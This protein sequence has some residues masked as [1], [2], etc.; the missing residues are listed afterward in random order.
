MAELVSAPLRLLE[1]WSQPCVWAQWPTRGPDKEVASESATEREVKAVSFSQ[2]RLEYLGCRGEG[3]RRAGRKK[4][5]N[6]RLHRSD[7]D[8]L[9]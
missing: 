7:N 1:G 3:G 2:P 9:T 8:I 5:R 4:S 6:N